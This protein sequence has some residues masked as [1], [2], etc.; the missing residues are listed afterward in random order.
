[1]VAGIKASL[2]KLKDNVPVSVDVVSGRYEGLYGLL[3]LN[4][5]IGTG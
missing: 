5:K 3:S 1:M 4:I 2:T